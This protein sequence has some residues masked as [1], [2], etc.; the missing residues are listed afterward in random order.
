M[1]KNGKQKNTNKE[2]HK[3]MFWLRRA[4]DTTYLLRHQLF[5]R[6]Q[7]DIFPECSPES[8]LKFIFV[9]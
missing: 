1:R 7:L 5:I 4:A 3:G 2:D 8:V 6:H 9:S